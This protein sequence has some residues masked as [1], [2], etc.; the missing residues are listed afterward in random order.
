MTITA[1]IE[2]IE[3]DRIVAAEQGAAR[4]RRRIA[5]AEI[6]NLLEVIEAH[7]L[8]EDTDELTDEMRRQ[9][10]RMADVVGVPLP[11][12]AYDAVTIVE[13]HSTL[14]DWQEK[15]LDITFPDR[16]HFGDPPL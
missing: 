16:H 5:M 4:R 2:D 12:V 10:D 8:T 6:D 1:A 9:L 15:V 13:L 11:D 3:R 7:L 14:L